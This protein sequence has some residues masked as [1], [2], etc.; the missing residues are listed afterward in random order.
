MGD[1]QP[2]CMTVR[3]VAAHFAV[4][5][6]TVY[7][8]CRAGRLPHLRLPGGNIRVRRSDIATFEASQWQGQ[9]TP[10]QSTASAKTDMASGRSPGPRLGARDPFQRGRAT[11]AKRTAG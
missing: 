5:A 6:E 7:A 4:S 10:S 8:W 1:S 11:A 3:D 2:P 9:E